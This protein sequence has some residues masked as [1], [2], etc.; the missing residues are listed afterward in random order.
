MA[1]FNY[2][3]DEQRNKFKTTY[4]KQEMFMKMTREMRLIIKGDHRQGH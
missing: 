1:C 2:S 3:I 4:L